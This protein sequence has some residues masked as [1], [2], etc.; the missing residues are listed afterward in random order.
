MIVNMVAMH[1]LM[2]TMKFQTVKA[3]I[4]KIPLAVE[5]KARNNKKLTTVKKMIW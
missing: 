3:Q 5:Q 4:T 2:T 1:L